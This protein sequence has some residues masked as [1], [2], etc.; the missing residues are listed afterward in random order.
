MQ[1]TVNIDHASAPD[2]NRL[3]DTLVSD[4]GCS[5]ALTIAITSDSIWNLLLKF[6]C[7]DIHS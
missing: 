6:R 4:E 3:I 5:E 2:W 7:S 1:I